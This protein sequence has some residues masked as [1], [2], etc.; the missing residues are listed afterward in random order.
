M[1]LLLCNAINLYNRGV[2]MI[3]REIIVLYRMDARIDVFDVQYGDRYLCMIVGDLGLDTDSDGFIY[4][5]EGSLD[6]FRKLQRS[7][8]TCRREC[9]RGGVT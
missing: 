7:Y 6:G 4:L 3:L 1:I 5:S 2:P 9:G 8:I